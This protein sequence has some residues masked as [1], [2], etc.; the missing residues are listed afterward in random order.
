MIGNISYENYQNII[1][2]LTLSKENIKAI[3]EIYK[4]INNDDIIR[5][6]NTFLSELEKYIKYLSITLKMNIDA[7]NV[8]QD[9]K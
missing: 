2:E 7:D 3:V 6:M 8:L 4:N 5:D 1:N 9:N